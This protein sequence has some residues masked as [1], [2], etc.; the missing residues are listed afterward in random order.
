MEP[1]V[2]IWAEETKSKSVRFQFKT[3]SVTDCKYF[4]LTHEKSTPV[5]MGF[6]WDFYPIYF[7]RKHHRSYVIFASHMCFR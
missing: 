4:T 3:V 7:G 5:R 1:F 2:I 6:Q